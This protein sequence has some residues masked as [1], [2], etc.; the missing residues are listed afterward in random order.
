MTLSP[1]RLV[2]LFF[3]LPFAFCQSFAFF[4]DLAGFKT[5]LVFQNEPFREA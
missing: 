1:T 3:C 2:G 5:S 4:G